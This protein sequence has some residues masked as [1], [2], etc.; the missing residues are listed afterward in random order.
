[1][2]SAVPD[3]NDDLPQVDQCETARKK[4]IRMEREMMVREQICQQA[5]VSDKKGD[6]KWSGDN[7]ETQ[8]DAQLPKSHYYPMDNRNRFNSPSQNYQANPSN[9]N[10]QFSS[11]IPND[12]VKPSNDDALGFQGCEECKRVGFHEPFCSKAPKGS[13]KC[14][15]CQ[16]PDHYVQSCPQKIDPKQVSSAVTKCNASVSTLEYVAV[17]IEVNAWEKV[18]SVGLNVRK[19]NLE[20]NKTE[21]ETAE[22]GLVFKN[23]FIIE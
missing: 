2:A 16:S 6:E 11:S 23:K 14:F 17:S 3:K 12:E 4:A 22:T 18:K 9:K 10:F 8:Q 1:M 15:V 13:K 7:V 5:S 20:K 19:E 21:N